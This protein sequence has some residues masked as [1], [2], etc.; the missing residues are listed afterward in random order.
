[1]S[2][3]DR[4]L[5]HRRCHNPACVDQT[6]HCQACGHGS[7]W[8][9]RP[10]LAAENAAYAALHSRAVADNARISRQRDLL[11]VNARRQRDRLA[12]MTATT[13]GSTR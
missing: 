8:P 2:P 13:E 11:A 5:P 1:M 9:C 4:A 6:P 3:A 12:A 7:G 10:V